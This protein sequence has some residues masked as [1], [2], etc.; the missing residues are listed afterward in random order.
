MK[1]K[2][3]LHLQTSQ[4]SETIDLR[5]YFPPNKKLLEF[6]TTLIYNEMTAS[7]NPNT[8]KYD[9]YDDYDDYGGRKNRK[10]GDGKS[11]KYIAKSNPNEPLHFED[12][13]M[14]Y[15]SHINM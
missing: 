13:N 1:I 4:A 2:T 3:K 14:A 8:T 9:K 11:K 15:F 6:D 12:C 5:M 10:K 7:T